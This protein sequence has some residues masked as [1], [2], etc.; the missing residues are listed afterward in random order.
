ME[1]Y[2]FLHIWFSLIISRLSWDVHHDS[3][4]SCCVWGNC[5]LLA[6][7]FFPYV[8]FTCGL[9]DTQ[10]VVRVRVPRSLRTV[11]T[12]IKHVSGSGGM[13]ETSDEAG[14]SSEGRSIFSSGPPQHSV[15]SFYC[16]S[17][18]GPQLPRPPL[19]CPAGLSCQLSTSFCSVT[20]LCENYYNYYHYYYY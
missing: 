7:F 14:G 16:K 13:G 12:T 2:T 3:F 4:V 1:L 9:A 6:V 11:R 20:M 18:H 19:P 10:S 5:Y 15:L 17:F 8:R